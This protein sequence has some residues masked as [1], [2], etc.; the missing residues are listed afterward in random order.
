MTGNRRAFLKLS[1]T[2]L[3]AAAFSRGITSFLS[4]ELPRAEALGPAPEYEIYAQAM[5]S[6]PCLLDLWRFIPK[7]GCELKLT[8]A[9]LLTSLEVRYT[10]LLDT[11][12]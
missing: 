6:F 7:K 8:W 2:A 9:L 3:G 5:E 4:Q 10:K 1:A 11:S 12:C